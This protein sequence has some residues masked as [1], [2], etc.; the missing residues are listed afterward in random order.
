[1]ASDYLA[2][3]NTCGQTLLRLVAR[4]NAVI[5]ELF[6]LSAYIPD[7]FKSL[8]ASNKYSEI[9]FDFSYLSNQVYYDTLIQKKQHLQA[10]DDELKFNHLEILSRFYLAFESIHKYV[11][12]LNRFIED[13][14]EGIFIQQNVDTVLFNQD[15]KQL[16]TEAIYLYGLMLLI[17]DI[18]FQGDVRERLLIAYVRYSNQK[19]YMES[20]IDD[21]CKLLRS[22]SFVVN[23]ARPAGYP[24]SYFQRVKINQ[25][26][27][28]QVIGRLR[29]DDL[30]A[31]MNSFP[32][33]EHRSH[34]LSK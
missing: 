26:V 6:R 22:T 25:D 30:Y 23:R 7:A 19:S 10:L 20:N 13:L 5:S 24:E 18:K 27:L 33:P 2:E 8:G 9:I 31:Q 16:L 15:G 14:D 11:M 34:A 17:T 1:M 3:N 21:V 29:T 12:D 32:Q 28:N 4:G